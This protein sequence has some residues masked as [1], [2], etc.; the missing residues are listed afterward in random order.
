[1]KIGKPHTKGSQTVDV[2]RLN[3]TSIGAEIR[4]A[5]VVSQQQHDIRGAGCRNLCQSNNRP[6]YGH[7]K[8]AKHCV[9]PFIVAN[10][11]DSGLFSI[12]AI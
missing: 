7:T 5:E 3:F 11:H 10:T 6:D 8:S 12:F 9:A 4:K 2:R 1:M